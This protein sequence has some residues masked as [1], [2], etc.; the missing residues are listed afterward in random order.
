MRIIPV[1]ILA[2]LF[3]VAVSIYTWTK[4]NVYTKNPTI[5]MT[6]H[7]FHFISLCPP[8]HIQHLT[9]RSKTW[10]PFH[11]IY[12]RNPIPFLLTMKRR[13]DQHYAHNLNALLALL[14]KHPKRMAWQMNGKKSNHNSSNILIHGNIAAPRAA[15]HKFSCMLND[16]DLIWFISIAIII[17]HSFFCLRYHI[18]MTDCRCNIKEGLYTF[19]L[20][21]QF[22]STI[23]Q[24]PNFAKFAKDFN[25]MMKEKCV[26]E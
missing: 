4:R 5:L 24:K 11:S 1:T 16:S 21:T 23:T 20:Y 9:Q 22:V 8:L 17:F 26:Y 12:S 15:N 3:C 10:S 2:A 6:I 13:S 25:K 14:V 7:W 19:G 18:L